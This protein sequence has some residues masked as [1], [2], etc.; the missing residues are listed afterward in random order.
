MSALAKTCCS[1]HRATRKRRITRA[2]AQVKEFQAA[3]NAATNEIAR[4]VRNEST[5]VI[6]NVMKDQLAPI[7]REALTEDVLRAINDLM[8]LTPAAVSALKQDLESEDVHVRHRAAALV[9][10]YTIGHPALIRPSDTDGAGQLVVN[11]NLPRPET[12]NIPDPD[13]EHPEAEEIKVCD[14]C[15]EDKPASEFEAGSERCSA[16]FE[17]WKTKITEQFGAVRQ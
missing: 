15:G 16:C 17:E 8:G 1:A 9:T 5:S 12:D 10:K 4:I 2:N 7:V 14:M 6:S 11:L 3:N 13:A